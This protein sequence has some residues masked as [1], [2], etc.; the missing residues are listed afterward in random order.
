MHLSKISEKNPI[1]SMFIMNIIV[2]SIS[3]CLNALSITLLEDILKPMAE[4]CNYTV[5]PEAEARL[6]KLLGV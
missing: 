5:T 3:S 1:N 2:S 6:A 4:T